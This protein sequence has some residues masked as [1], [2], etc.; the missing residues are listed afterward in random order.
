[1]HPDRG[2]VV[3]S[4]WQADTCTATFRLRLVDSARLIAALADGM[5]AGLPASVA[6]AEALAKP[7]RWRGFL[8]FSSFRSGGPPTPDPPPTPEPPHLRAL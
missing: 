3:V 8:W 4:L 6:E 5:A 2:L 1:M 7:R